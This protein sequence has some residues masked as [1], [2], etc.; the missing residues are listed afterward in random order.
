MATAQQQTYEVF[1]SGS[2]VPIKSWTVGVPFEE[3]QQVVARREAGD[4]VHDVARLVGGA[5]VI[6]WLIGF[7]DLG[8]G[9]SGMALFWCGVVWL[10]GYMSGWQALARWARG[11]VLA[12]A[13]KV[14]NVGPVGVT[15][16]YDPTANQWAAGPDIGVPRTG[17]ASPQLSSAWAAVHS[18]MGRARFSSG[19]VVARVMK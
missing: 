13:G 16:I 2:G 18:K 1:S 11:T 6:H 12:A 17:S 9:Y 4:A 5:A 15:E 10:L 14:A 7:G 8:K 3:A 19:M